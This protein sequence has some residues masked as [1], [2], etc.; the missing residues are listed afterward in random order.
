MTRHRRHA[1]LVA[2]LIASLACDDDG[3]MAAR[4]VVER[5]S[6]GIPIV[7]NADPTDTTT[8]VRLAHGEPRVTI[9]GSDADGAHAFGRIGGAAR[10]DDGTVVVVDQMAAEARFF[11]ATGRHVRT[12]GRAGDG[13]GEFRDPLLLARTAGDTLLVTDRN[14]HRVT[15]LA[16]DGRMLGRVDL[17][18]GRAGVPER[19][20]G[21]FAD[22]TLLARATWSSSPTDR[23]GV[24]RVD[25]DWLR[26][27]ADGSSRD[28]I[29][30]HFDFY[31]PMV[32]AGASR[33]YVTRPFE[34]DAGLAADPDGFWLGDPERWELRRYDRDGALHR[35]VRLDREPVPIDPSE[36]E[37]A[38]E[39]F[40]SRMMPQF[41]AALREL[42]L[43][44]TYPPYGQL[45]LDG[46]RRLW[47]REYATA[48]DDA[49]PDRD[50]PP[51]PLRWLVHDPDG[52]FL[53]AVVLPPRTRP[54]EIGPDYLLLAVRDGSDVERVELHDLPP[55]PGAPGR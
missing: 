1:R 47:V 44:E 30:R 45:R 49:W 35:I 2:L 55:L 23:P 5:D 4:A 15:M 46:T 32:A 26:I 34:R 24:T 3:R 53:A 6:A 12:V 22:G 52:R 25:S 14:R 17:T 50:A 18:S 33:M 10:L 43:P 7:E 54:L 11:D 27:A 28:T 42:P 38:R 21:R 37:R 51:P 20:F 36:L 39:R 16:A 29:G 8:D 40:T 19:V 9:G 13:P 41:R 31:R 48:A